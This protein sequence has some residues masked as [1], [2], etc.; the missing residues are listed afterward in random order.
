MARNNPVTN[1]VTKQIPGS[2]PKFHQPLIIDGAGKCTGA[3]FVILNEGCV[4][5]VG[6]V[7]VLCFVAVPQIR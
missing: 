4:F 7:I 6:F 1:C 2:D 3:S 5:R